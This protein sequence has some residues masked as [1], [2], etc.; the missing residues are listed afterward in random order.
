MS[1]IQIFFKIV[2]IG[3]VMDSDP[4]PIDLLFSSLFPY[5]CSPIRSWRWFADYSVRDT[6]LFCRYLLEEQ[7][8]VVSIIF[9]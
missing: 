2:I 8:C 9:A 4:F 7:A 3:P 5:L 1:T 6:Y